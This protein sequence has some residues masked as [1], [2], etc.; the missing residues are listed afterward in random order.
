MPGTMTLTTMPT[1]GQDPMTAL[2]GED[3]YLV[4][5]WPAVQTRRVI[6]SPDNVIFHPDGSFDLALTTAPDGTW[7][8][9][10][11]GEVASVETGTYGTWTWN[12]QVPRMVAGAVFG[13]F[14]FQADAAAPRV[15]FDFEFVG[16]DTTKLELNVHMAGPDGRN[17]SLAGGPLTV[18]LGFDAAAARHVY[19]VTVTEGAA[20]FTIDGTVVATFGPEDMTNGVWREGEMRSY[21]DLWAVNDD[22]I[23]NWAGVWDGSGVPM[24][25]SVAALDVPDGESVPL[26]TDP[27]P[28]LPPEPPPLPAPDAQPSTT[29]GDSPD[30]ATPPAVSLPGLQQGTDGPD[31]L[32][33]GRGTD[34]LLGGAAND[35]LAGERG[36]NVVDGGAGNDWLSHAFARKPLEIDLSDPLPQATGRSTDLIRGVE[37]LQGGKGGDRLTG[38]AGA[39]ILEG[40]GGRDRINGGAGADVIIGGRGRDWLD[41]GADRDADTFVFRQAA[42]SPRAGGGDRVLNFVSGVDHIDLS[43]IDAR[44]DLAGSQSL[45]LADGLADHAVWL[46]AGARG[47]AVLADVTGDGRADLRVFV[48]G[49]V[50]VDDLIL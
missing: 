18:D 16:A 28:D 46:Q 40:M 23:Q 6:W 38:D 20:V 17:V 9:Y 47:T 8:P 44:P 2:A 1:G 4:S 19:A 48:L 25:A 14:T 49:I 24:L 27:A 11:S 36:D 31:V 29:D 5:D 15:E 42:D 21:V 26:P 22:G 7:R 34:V 35:F 30:M 37:N 50:T 3:A 41:G 13:M 12:A 45:G 32:I 43:R 39:N 10:L 33:G